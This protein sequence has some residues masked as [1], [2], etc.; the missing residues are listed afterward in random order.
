MNRRLH[1]PLTLLAS[2][3]FVGA[4]V[5][6]GPAKASPP[7]PR[8]RLFAPSPSIT[9][10]RYR[11]RNKISV[12]SG[13]WVSASDSTF[14]VIA[15]RADYSSPIVA[16]Q[17]ID[18]DTSPREVVLPDGLVAPGWSGFR[19]FLDVTVTGP[20]GAVVFNRSV[21]FCP[22]SWNVQ[23]ADAT[24]PMTPSF[25]QGCYANPFT[26]GVVWGIDQGWAVGALDTSRIRF[27]G[28]D[29]TYA[30]EVHI[31]P[32]YQRL[33]A[34]APADATASFDLVVSTGCNPFCKPAATAA[35]AAG[36]SQTLPTRTNPRPSTLP[37]LVALPAWGISTDA[38]RASGK[39]FLDFGATVWD[40]G[41]APMVVEG[42]RRQGTNVMDAWQTF[43]RGDTP[44]ARAPVGTLR[45]DAKPGHE[46]W[47][48]EQFATY[49]L[50]GAD[51]QQIVR[52]RKT[53]FCLAPTDAIDLTVPG[54]VWNPGTIGL[55]S[56]CGDASAIW[57]RETLPA[58]W[59]DTYF[60]SLPGQ[61]FDITDLPNGTYFIQ[62]QADPTG[63]IYER[64]SS[65]DTQVREVIL[66]GVPGN[67]TVTVPPWH[68]IDTG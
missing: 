22:D 58:G 30:V 1:A 6:A 18:P 42:F 15:Q 37:D 19:R 16:T 50:L 52:S 65:N 17:I 33:F 66:G 23:R 62:V 20:T 13:L 44:I 56:A 60:Q 24:G 43:Y 4:M 41:P 34:I 8:L 53:G 55:W 39:D 64:S 35:G 12:D 47:H 10:A 61:S 36:S 40:A 67:R 32:T 45:Y 49:R 26:K 38:R 28:P 2:L 31:T 3:A 29:G 68:G 5:A 9:E 21:R 51:K 14:E 59:G 54:A 57:I 63:E 25:P 11:A 7:G 27:S 48:F 46:H